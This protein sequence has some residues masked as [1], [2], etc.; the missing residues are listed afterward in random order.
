MARKRKSTRKTT[1]VPA[2]K[3]WRKALQLL[4]EGNERFCKLKGPGSD[5][6]P[7]SYNRCARSETTSPAWPWNEDS[8]YPW[9]VVVSCADS[10]V[11]PEAVFDTAIGE[12]FVIRVAGNVAN[13]ETVAS[14]E[15]AVNALTPAPKLVVVLGHEN[16]GA[17]DAA[18][19][20]VHLG[21]NLNSLLQP[22]KLAITRA[23]SLNGAVKDN[24]ENTV[25]ELQY[26]VRDIPD[27]KAQMTG[28]KIVPAYYHLESGRVEFLETKTA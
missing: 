20:D 22:I 16:C 15:Y 3:S 18:R 5:R 27:R 2:G 1:G 9:A 11:T 26:Q 6:G 19:K 24:V 13:V 14:I 7:R 12:L 10:R 4:E 23:R 25:R 21:F 17:V 8:Q 28:I